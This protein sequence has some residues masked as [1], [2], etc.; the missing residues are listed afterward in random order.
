[1]TNSRGLEVQG[2]TE[3]TEDCPGGRYG[4]VAE[5]REPDGYME[6]KAFLAFQEKLPMTSMEE[7][8]RL[9]GEAQKMY[10]SYGV[11]TVQDGMVAGDGAGICGTV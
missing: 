4:R 7:L 3:A 8:M 1:M 10:A 2:I 9:I 6:E 5:T 11:T